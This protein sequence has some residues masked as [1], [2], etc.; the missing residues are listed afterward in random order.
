MNGSMKGYTGKILHISLPL[1]KITIEEPSEQFYAKY[2]G[3]VG[4]GVKLLYDNTPPRIDPYHPE[5]TF[6]LA[7][8]HFSGMGI[9]TSGKYAAIS[10]SPLTS[11]IGFGISSGFFGP[12]L[13]YAG[14]DAV[15]IRGRSRGQT[16]LF[17]DDDEVRLRNA[18]HLK[19][20][21]TV[22]T[23]KQ[24][25]EEIGD[26]NVRIACVGP[27]AEHLVRYACI[28]NDITRQVGRTGLGAVM[29]SKNLKAIAIRGT[30]PVEVD[31]P[32]K[33]MQI[34]GEFYERCQTSSTEKYRDLG[35]PQN[36]L[37]LNEHGALPTKNF[38]YTT[39]EHAEAISGEMLKKKFLRKVIACNACAIGC[40]HIV[41]VK[42]G[43]YA[44]AITGLDY[45]SLFALGCCCGV[46]DLR[47]VIK[48]AE[49]CDALGMDTMSAG[50]TIAFAMECFEKGLIT[51]EDTNGIDL[52]FGNGDAVVQMVEKIAFREGLG[53]LL[54]EGTKRASE[55]IGKGSTH[56]AM[57]VKGLELPGYSIR[58]LNTAA[59][60]FSVSVRGGCH[61]RN[62][63]YSPD[64]K[65]QVDRFKGDV[66]RGKLL[67]GTENLYSVFDS[68]ILCKFMRGAISLEEI[69]MLYTMTTGIHM[70]EF[71]LL[72][73]GERITNL[74][75][76]YNI[77]EGATRADDYPPPRVFKDPIPDGVAKGHYIRKEEYEAMLDGYYAARGWTREGIPTKAKL[78]D[79]GLEDLIKELYRVEVKVRSSH[80]D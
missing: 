2:L 11:L 14:Y 29:G 21:D 50:V 4:L 76:A 77:R 32:E 24:I 37:V 79:L 19:G 58:G 71:E 25:R 13:K 49:L 30:N 78:I 68:I 34:C 8:G 31:V 43:P 73:A 3:G 20:K 36:V 46:G 12:T 60:G 6:I 33:L 61:Q 22:E 62:A 69:A 7:T 74:E 39:F 51:L 47:P 65:G 56:F 41:Q 9:P 23:E 1:G 38:Q 16:Y 53:D 26:D 64:L 67:I 52:S 42:E 66:E 28:T 18:I 10:K 5:N 57:H 80:G 48:A 44:G 55:K 27:A 70:S 17:I 59:L 54:A 63:G 35:T 72:L 45:E 15:V 40:D 75:K